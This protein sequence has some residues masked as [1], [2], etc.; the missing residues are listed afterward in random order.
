LTQVFVFSAI[1][2]YIF[3]TQ[4]GLEVAFEMDLKDSMTIPQYSLIYFGK[5]IKQMLKVKVITENDE[6]AAL[7]RLYWEI[8]DELKFV[9][10]VASIENLTTIEGADIRLTSIVKE[11]CYA[12]VDDWKCPKCE[13]P[14]KFY[15]RSDW[16][17]RSSIVRFQCDDCREKENAERE[18]ARQRK[19]QT[20]KQE[21]EQSRSQKRK[22][23][24]E[25]YDLSK[26]RAVH[27]YGLSVTVLIYLISMM[28]G[29]YE[30]LTKI[31]PIEMFDQPLTPDKEFT[32]EIINHLRGQDLLYIHPD[33]DPDAFSED[34]L[35]RYYPFLASWAPL[36]SEIEGEAPKDLVTH[37]HQV[38]NASWLED[39]CQEALEIWKKIALAECKEYLIYVLN[40]H[41][42]E[43]TAGEKTTQY[44]EYALE[45]FSTAQVFNMI[46]RAG[47]DA[48]AYYQRGGIT[49]QH[50]ANT[51]VT[52]IQ[53]QAEKAITE[54]WDL[55]PFRRNYQIKQS[56]VSDVFYNL[57]IKLG[58]EGFEMKPNIEIIRTRKLTKEIRE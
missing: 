34:D 10:T 9:H 5:T 46:W 6:L 26:R 52:S 45:S 12:Y 3:S 14:Y 51:A 42:L 36:L 8:N 29:A 7:C 2:A 37:L 40:E 57:A 56:I 11:S 23:I 48:A 55:K 27:P 19:I 33:T 15:S 28:R 39:E 4:K 35:S 58:D 22:K 20:E 47:R 25:I 44:L 49:K 41:R 1:P 16:Q 53:R 18:A 32:L 31:M 30:D 17:R 24:E 54:K 50:A 43:F 13:Q 21:K 38:L